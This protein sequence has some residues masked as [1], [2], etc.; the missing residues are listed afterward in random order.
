MAMIRGSRRGAGAAE[1]EIVRGGS[2]LQATVTGTA[3]RL[4]CAAESAT[5]VTLRS[6]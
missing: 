5:L 4:T 6:T 3:L 2:G 1:L